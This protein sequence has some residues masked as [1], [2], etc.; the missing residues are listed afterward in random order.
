M[1]LLHALPNVDD[2][3]QN[4]AFRRFFYSRWGRENC[5]I[6]AR[7]RTGTYPPYTQRL[8]I[9]CAWGGSERYHIDGRTVAVDDDNYLVI[10]D[11]GQYASSLE[12][13]QPL[14]TFSIF[15]RPGMA[16]ETLG[17]MLIATDRL[18]ER[19]REPVRR[20]VEFA[21]YLR[22]HDKTVTPALRFIA[23]HVDRGLGDESWYEL[24]GDRKSVV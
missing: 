9:K 7:A 22:P 20:G 8:S 21:E 2:T 16:E 5:L 4:A 12:S 10:N 19:G 13:A 17:G 1:L 6:S 23:H 11:G 18:L 14:H 3:P 24:Y 15:F